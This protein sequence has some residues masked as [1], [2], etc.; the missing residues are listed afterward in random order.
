M[1]EGERPTCLSRVKPTLSYRESLAFRDTGSGVDKADN[2]VCLY[3][4][5]LYSTIV[6][7]DQSITASG[8]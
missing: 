7:K 5:A 2:A 4:N 6:L 3:L 8:C 1:R